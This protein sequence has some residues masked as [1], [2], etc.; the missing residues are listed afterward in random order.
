MAVV[1]AIAEGAKADVPDALIERELEKMMAELKDSLG[2][3]N[4][5][6]N[7]YL[8]HLKKAEADL[9]REWNKDALRRVKIAL[10]LHE[11]S[12]REGI[13][14]LEE[15]IQQALNRTVAHRG[16]SEENLKALDREAFIRYHIGIARN[17]K[18][19]E[20]LENTETRSSP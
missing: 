4:L 12:R 11:I 19:F 9:K 16:M 13:E 15:E 6:F 14:P 17:E 1:D 3:M 5:K 10:V 2:G 7:D 20:F 18:V 8:L